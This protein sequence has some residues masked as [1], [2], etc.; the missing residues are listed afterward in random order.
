MRACQKANVPTKFG[1][2]IRPLFEYAS[3][4]WSS[5]P[6]YLVEDLQRVRDRSQDIIGVCRDGLEPLNTRRDAQTV[7]AFESIL[8]DLR[9]SPM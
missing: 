9:S 2:K 8:R 6:L 3:P 5:L 4:I 7:A 1:L